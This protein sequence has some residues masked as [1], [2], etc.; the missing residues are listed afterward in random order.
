MK[1]ENEIAAY[2]A[3]LFDGEG[4][5]SVTCNRANTRPY[6]TAACGISNQ[7]RAV[8]DWIKT[9]FGGNV[10]C[11]NPPKDSRAR[12][13]YA[14]VT[15]SKALITAF[16]EAVLPYLRIKRRQAELGIEFEVGIVGLGERVTKE[17]AARREAI[18][19]EL[20]SLNAKCRFV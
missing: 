1:K 14:W 17:E 16:L 18:R 10:Y 2:A 13:T 5:V 3:G 19:L 6:L 20:R 11:S 9:L 7:N 12:A 8:L 15:R 4:H